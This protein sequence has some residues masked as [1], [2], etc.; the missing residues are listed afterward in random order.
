MPVSSSDA[1][2]LKIETPERKIGNIPE[3]IS[4]PKVF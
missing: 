4:F 3:K 2:N 1:L